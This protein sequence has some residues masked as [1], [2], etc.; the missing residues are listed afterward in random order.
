MDLLP[1]SFSSLPFLAALLSLMLLFFVVLAAMDQDCDSDDGPAAG[2]T[3]T[4]MCCFREARPLRFSS[5]VLGGS[6]WVRRVL[7]LDV[8]GLDCCKNPKITIREGI[9]N[10]KVLHKKYSPSNYLI[11]F[12]PERV[13]ISSNSE[14][15][16]E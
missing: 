9:T 3:M 12:P 16:L 8:V 4:L 14:Q 7:I 13:D 2:G 1:V 6:C 11:I 5:C 10:A 15:Q